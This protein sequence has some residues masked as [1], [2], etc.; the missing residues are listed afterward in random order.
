MSPTAT[1]RTPVMDTGIETCDIAYGTSVEVDAGADPDLSVDIESSSRRG[2]PRPRLYGGGVPNRSRA[3]AAADGTKR[4]GSPTQ[5]LP[6]TLGMPLR[7]QVKIICLQ[8]ILLSVVVS[9]SVVSFYHFTHLNQYNQLEP[10]AMSARVQFSSQQGSFRQ[11]GKPHVKIPG[12][13]W[14]GGKHDSVPIPATSFA[15]PATTGKGSTGLVKTDE[16]I[17]QANGPALSDGDKGAVRSEGQHE[18]LGIFDHRMQPVGAQSEAETVGAMQTAALHWFTGWGFFHGKSK[19][20][21]DV[22]GPLE[23]THKSL[24]RTVDFDLSENHR[25]DT[26]DINS[27][28]FDAW[29]QDAVQRD[30]YKKG[31]THST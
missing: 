21:P 27:G 31:A 17:G 25:P 18:A 29:Q 8:F 26:A 4:P 15:W 22:S 13:S 5:P 19:G 12:N 2:R 23:S 11:A 7:Q 10:Q 30:H 14:F 6:P 9:C 16:V 24:T 28:A 20:V 1:A 3:A